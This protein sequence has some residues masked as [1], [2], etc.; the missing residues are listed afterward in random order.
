MTEAGKG[1]AGA[2]GSAAE[3][4]IELVETLPLRYLVLAA[5]AG[6]VISFAILYALSGRL[7]APEETEG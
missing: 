7:N 6:F 4:I 2:A 5:A 3:P 1:A